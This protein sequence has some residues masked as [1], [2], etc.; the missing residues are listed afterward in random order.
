MTIIAYK[1]GEHTETYQVC[2]CDAP[3]HYLVV[4]HTPIPEFDET[5]ELYA[6]LNTLIEEVER[7]GRSSTDEN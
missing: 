5:A 7:H 3:D 2:D 1:Y 6:E 4:T